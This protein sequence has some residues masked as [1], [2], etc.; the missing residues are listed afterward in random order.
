MV[1]KG[2]KVNMKKVENNI[3]NSSQ[4]T[5]HGKNALKATRDIV[6]RTRL[7]VKQ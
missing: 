1:C 6:S 3:V 5:V 2:L 7:M 4:L